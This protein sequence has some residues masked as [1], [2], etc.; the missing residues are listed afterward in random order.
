MITYNLT[1]QYEI[2]HNDSIQISYV[3]SLSRHLT[4]LIGFNQPNVLIAPGFST[5]PFLPFPDFSGGSLHDTNGVAE[6]N[7]ARVEYERR[8]SSGLSVLANYTFARC[9]ADNNPQEAGVGAR[10]PWLPGFGV[11]GEYTNCPEGV[12]HTIHISGTYKLPFGPK[13]HW[14]GNGATNAVLGGW[15]LNWIYT[16]PERQLFRSGLHGWHPRLGLTAY[17][18]FRA[19]LM[20]AAHTVNHWLNA[21]ACVSTM[22]RNPLRRSTIRRPECYITKPISRF[23]GPRNNDVHRAVVLQH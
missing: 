6:Y 2:T 3:G 10:A 19:I 15:Q 1:N 20:P 9:L 11:R 17:A 12:E 23:L 7:S 14:Q 21:S 5:R 16:L 13:M 4:N 8:L 22:R 18:A